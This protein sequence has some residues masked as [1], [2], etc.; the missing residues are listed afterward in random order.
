MELRQIINLVWKWL[1]LVVLAVGIAAG[2]SYYASKS[3]TPLYKA[4]ATLMVGQIIQD[5]NLSSS[6]IYTTYQLANTYIQFVNRE[7]VMSGTIEALGLEMDWRNLASRVS[8]Y[9]VPQTQ[10]IQISVIDSD[11]YRAKVLADTIAHQLI[12]LSPANPNKIDEENVAFINQQIN[13]LRNNIEEGQKERERLSA[14]LNT[15]T[16]AREIQD[17]KNQLYSL[18]SRLSE[19][20]TN[21]TYLLAS[22][23]GGNIN[24]LSLIEE[25]TI[26]I[27]PFSPNTVNNVLVAAAIGAV[28][29][30]AGALLIEYLDDTVKSPEDISRHTNLTTLGGIPQ[31]SGED[32]Q[33]KLLA[34]HQPLSPIVEA[35]RILRTNLQF[36]ALDRPLYSLMITSP[37]PSEGKSIAISN[38]SVVIAQSGMKVILIDADLRRPTIHKIFN[39][40]NRRGLT[41]AI[42]HP[43]LVQAEENS[44]EK[45]VETAVEGVNRVGALFNNLEMQL[46]SLT[47]GIYEDEHNSINVNRRYPDLSE[48]LQT[49]PIENLLILPSGPLPPNPAELLASQRMLNLVSALKAQADILI[50][51]S[52]P[53][54]A[55]AD[56]AILSSRVNGTILITDVGRTRT[57]EA[58]RASEELRRVNANLLGVVLNRLSRRGGYNN[59]YYYYYYYHEDGKRK[60]K[61]S[62]MANLFPWISRNG[63]PHTKIEEP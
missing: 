59:R 17:I 50:F 38:L 5:P 27:Q 46:H 55:V 16:S 35:F 23:Q 33:T 52:P 25:A 56:A 1:W 28:L 9:T 6:A 13:N 26:P 47:D 21:Y 29:A 42:L 45:A 31:I 8:A 39:I 7:P 11:P 44:Q 62:K 10:F 41:D 32:Y 24:T 61:P 36:S 18:D 34:L 4:Q 20:Q 60:R 57:S 54:L 43:E 40:S 30:A 15:A 3:I 58:R 53:C 37:N 63:K 2:T 49:T 12:L 22:L 48:Y 51:D 14:E 19:W